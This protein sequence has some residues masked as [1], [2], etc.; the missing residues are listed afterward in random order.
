VAVEVVQEPSVVPE[1]IPLQLEVVLVV[2]VYII[3]YLV[4]ML[5]MLVVVEVPVMVAKA[6][7]QVQVALA[8][9]VPE[10]QMLEEQQ[11]L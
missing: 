3:L 2:L 9:E 1:Q 11:A 8:E 10:V 4:Q 7:H 5:L 6:S